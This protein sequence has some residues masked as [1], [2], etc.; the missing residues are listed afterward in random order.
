MSEHIEL[1]MVEKIVVIIRFNKGNPKNSSTPSSQ[2]QHGEP[3]KVVPQKAKGVKLEQ[4]D[5]SSY[6][7]KQGRK[8]NVGNVMGFI[9]RKFALIHFKLPH[10]TLTPTNYVPIV[11]FMGLMWIIISHYI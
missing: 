5:A 2:Q 7:I 11:E 8:K 9:G 3:N 6:S 4:C 10:P 1:N